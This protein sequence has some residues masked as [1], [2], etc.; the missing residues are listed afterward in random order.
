MKNCRIFDHRALQYFNWLD[1]VC[2]LLSS[3]ISPSEPTYFQSKLK[4]F[5]KTRKTTTHLSGSS[6]TPPI[7]QFEH[8]F[9]CSTINCQFKLDRRRANTETK[10]RTDSSFFFFCL[11]SLARFKSNQLKRIQY[12]LMTRTHMDMVFSMA[13]AVWLTTRS[14]VARLHYV[15][16]KSTRWLIAIVVTCVCDTWNSNQ[17]IQQQITQRAWRATTNC[18]SNESLFIENDLKTHV[19]MYATQL[20]SQSHQHHAHSQPA[21]VFEC[22]MDSTR[23]RFRDVCNVF[24]WCVIGRATAKELTSI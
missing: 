16:T 22:L 1:A 13:F 17:P 20:L 10:I 12:I 18:H 4:K 19:N 8:Y 3:R 14:F 11:V 23:A 2:I 21:R 15:S 9:W 6:P 5:L 7:F 24:I